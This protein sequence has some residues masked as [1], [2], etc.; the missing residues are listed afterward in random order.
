[1]A[2]RIFPARQRRDTG[3][4]AALALIGA[5]ALS[6]LGGAPVQAGSGFMVPQR[7][8]PPPSG[9]RSLCGTYSW[10]C[11][12]DRQARLAPR[13]A[14][15]VVRR[16]NLAINARF[17]EISDARQYR[18]TEYWALPTRRGGDCED[19]A[20]AKKQAL[21]K[22]GVAPSQLLIAT[23]LD[24]KRRAHAVLIYRSE[25][26]DL[27]LDNQTDRILAWDRT[28]YVFLRMQDP[29]NPARWVSGFDQG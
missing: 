6:G 16:V 22:A 13:A 1:M 17:D 12:G 23:A 25:R 3:F 21:M 8:S 28:G 2:F 9:A 18:Q 5:M 27:V 7:I 26:G 15:D 24:K 10:A 29:A 11:A 19:F 20:L 14:F 4:R